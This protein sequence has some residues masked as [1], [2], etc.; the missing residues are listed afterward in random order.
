MTRSDFGRKPDIFGK[1]QERKQLGGAGELRHQ[2]NPPLHFCMS[3]ACYSVLWSRELGRNLCLLAQRSYNSNLLVYLAPSECAIRVCKLGQT[4]QCDSHCCNIHF[5]ENQVEP[6]FIGHHIKFLIYFV[7]GIIGTFWTILAM[8]SCF[9]VHCCLQL[10]FLH[11][12]FFSSFFLLSVFLFIL[13]FKFSRTFYCSYFSYI[14]SF[15]KKI[16][17][18]YPSLPFLFVL[19]I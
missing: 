2:W 12:S 7:V 19:V 4:S 13:F 14:Y 18:C 6:G 9:L 15:K 17:F 8:G 10:F 5:N 11:L 1:H 3:L 16:P